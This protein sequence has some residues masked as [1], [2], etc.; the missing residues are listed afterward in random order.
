MLYVNPLHNSHRAAPLLNTVAFLA[1]VL[2]EC[3][4]SMSARSTADKFYFYNELIKSIQESSGQAV[5]PKHLAEAYTQV[6]SRIEEV[7]PTGSKVLAHTAVANGCTAVVGCWNMYVCVSTDFP[8]L[9]SGACLHPS[10]VLHNCSDGIVNFLSLSALLEL[11]HP[12]K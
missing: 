10:G 1:P 2:N 9:G 7:C 4:E 8:P 5:T 3:T 12:C 6:R 11:P